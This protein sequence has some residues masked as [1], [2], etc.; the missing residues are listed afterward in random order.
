MRCDLLLAND[1]FAER[2]SGGL[3]HRAEGLD[4]I[5]FVPRAI[6][7]AMACPSSL[8]TSTRACFQNE[9]IATEIPTRDLDGTPP[10]FSSIL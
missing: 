1:A 5:P 8:L 2:A 4:V 3:G 7:S 10:H 9:P 6:P